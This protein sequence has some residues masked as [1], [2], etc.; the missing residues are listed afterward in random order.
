[1]ESDS[2]DYQV[3]IPG[4]THAAQEERS[5]AA[6]FSVRAYGETVHIDKN[7][8]GRYAFFCDTYN[9]S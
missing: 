3:E 9:S 4:P 2:P 5:V 8:V 1:M 6:Q 7:P